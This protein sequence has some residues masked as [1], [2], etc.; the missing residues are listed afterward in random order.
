MD[1]RAIIAKR[2]AD[3]GLKK[4]WLLMRLRTLCRGHGGCPTTSVYDFLSGKRKTIKVKTLGYILEA[5][6][7]SIEPSGGWGFFEKQWKRP[8]DSEKTIQP[9]E[10]WRESVELVDAFEKAEYEAREALRKL[11]QTKR[12]KRTN[13]ATVEELNHVAQ[14]IRELA[15]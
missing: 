3:E 8:A 5:L 6:K 4:K 9:A 7:L 11:I 13:L 1:I 12:Q 10:V 15:Q 14:I 2:M